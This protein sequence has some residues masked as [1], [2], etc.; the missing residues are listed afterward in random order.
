MSKLTTVLFHI[1]LMSAGAGCSKR[2]H[3]PPV[4]L[5]LLEQLRNTSTNEDWFVPLKK[6]TS[7]LTAE[8]ANWQDSTD[9]HS[10]G[11]LVSHLIFWNER[12]LTAFQAKTAAD[13]N[14]DNEVTFRRFTTIGW[15]QALARLDSTQINWYQS[16]ENAT[17]KQL[18]E[19]CSSIANVCSHNAY[20]T[21]QI[22]YIRKQHGWWPKPPTTK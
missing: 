19:W 11:Q 15:Q 16:V 21:G 10:I 9:N 13:F 2:V 12:I 22:I 18:A 14:S 17:D 4:R 1:L 6:A 3:A 20:H 8:Q 5:I 7:G